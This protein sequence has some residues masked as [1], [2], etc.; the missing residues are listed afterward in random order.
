MIALTLQATLG[1][2]TR[3]ERAGDRAL[4]QVVQLEHD[5]RD[6]TADLGT[7]RNGALNDRLLAALSASPILTTLAE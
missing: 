6:L 5:L 2:L 7:Y 3:D 4:Q 1:R